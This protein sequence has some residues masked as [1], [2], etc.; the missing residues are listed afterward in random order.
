VRLCHGSSHELRSAGSIIAS[1][2][3]GAQLASPAGP[4]PARMHRALTP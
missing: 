4:V 3:N 1:Q 2:A